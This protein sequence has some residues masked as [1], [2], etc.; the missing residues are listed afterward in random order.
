MQLYPVSHFYSFDPSDWKMD[1][2]HWNALENSGWGC[3][4]TV[5]PKIME[6][7]W[8][9]DFRVL[10]RF[11]RKTC[12]TGIFLPIFVLDSPYLISIPSTI[13]ISC[14]VS[15]FWILVFFPILT[16]WAKNI[17][18]LIET[19]LLVWTKSKLYT[20]NQSPELQGNLSSFGILDASHFFQILTRRAKNINFF[21]TE[22]TILVWS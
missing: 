18:M 7:S 3:L 22:T 11:G 2:F 14:L 15:E 20:R 10:P 6:K 16:R 1:A 4:G 8:I 5:C 17:K 13:W 21:F 12:L 9:F 19:K